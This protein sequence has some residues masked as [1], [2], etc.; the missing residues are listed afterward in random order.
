M[1]R[2]R[3]RLAVAVIGACMM[4]GISLVF[5]G[6]GPAPD[7]LLE[8]GQRFAPDI[9]TQADARGQ[10]SDT[11]GCRSASVPVAS[12]EQAWDARRRHFFG[13]QTAGGSAP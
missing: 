6:E 12:C 10:S 7:A 2:R 4:I 1:M 8:P 5:A 3:F 9:E 13:E 11:S